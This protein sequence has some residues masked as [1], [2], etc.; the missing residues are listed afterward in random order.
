MLKIQIDKNF[1]HF[2]KNTRYTD[3]KLNLDEISLQDIIHSNL[4]S[5]HK[6]IEKIKSTT[7]NQSFTNVDL[8]PNSPQ[9]NYLSCITPNL[10]YLNSRTCLTTSLYDIEIWIQ[11]Q[12]FNV[13]KIDK[14][15]S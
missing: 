11:N 13:I 2:V 5:L 7:C 10:N 14:L 8:I 12:T 4:R 1:K 6:S 3:S 15:K 9:R